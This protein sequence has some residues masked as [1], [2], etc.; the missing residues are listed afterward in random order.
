M[1]DHFVTVTTLAMFKKLSEVSNAFFDVIFFYDCHRL[2][3]RDWSIGNH[4]SR[5]IVGFTPL[6]PMEISKKLLCFF[7]KEKPSRNSVVYAF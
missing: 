6:H 4:V 5:S 7:G 2:T 3:Q 1:P